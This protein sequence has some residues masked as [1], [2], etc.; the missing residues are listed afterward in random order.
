M[1]EYLYLPLPALSCVSSIGNNVFGYQDGQLTFM[2]HNRRTPSCLECSR[3]WI[4][5]DSPKEQG[6]QVF[7][8]E[9]DVGWR[10]NL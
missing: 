7:T 5:E 9:G 4:Y 2:L 10:R 6:A 3:W 1:I 8:Q